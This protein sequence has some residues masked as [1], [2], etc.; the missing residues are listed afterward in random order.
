MKSKKRKSK[1]VDNKK[2]P[3]LKT[4]IKW[5]GNKS[6]HLRHILPYIPT[7]YNTYIEPFIGS[8]ALFL[9]VHPTNW[10]INDLNKDLINVW[11]NIKNNPDKIIKIFKDFRLKF[12]KLSNTKK[13]EY[14]RNLTDIFKNLEYDIIRSSIYMLLKFCS[15]SGNI[16]VNNKFYF[17]GL[18]MNIYIR[19]KY[20]FLDDNNFNN[21]LSVSNY[22]NTTKGKIYNKD[23]KFILNKSKY[24]DFIFLDPP[25]IEEH[26]YGF[27][28]NE[29]EHLTLNFI[30]ELYDELKKLDKKGVKW[31]M[32]QT[33]TKDIKKI[34]KDYNII[35]F[36]VYRSSV[37]DYQN[38][39]I[40]KNY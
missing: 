36:P 25:Y 35:K 30:Y 27:N 6:K 21:I 26:N 11:E 38:E 22:L 5:S 4:F 34:F 24:G 39:L 28:Y 31:L 14:C 1:N 16:I 29:N 40:I 13:I 19:D 37:K 33:D 3:K 7:E 9:S 17:D 23:Y 10:I 15:Y 12:K 18:D 2:S 8:G 32:T 20:F